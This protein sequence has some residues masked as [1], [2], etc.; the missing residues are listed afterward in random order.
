MLAVGGMHGGGTERQLVQ[1]LRH[2]DRDRFMPQLYLVYRTGPLLAEIP[3]DV[4]VHV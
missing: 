4:P 2:L 3:A 1:I